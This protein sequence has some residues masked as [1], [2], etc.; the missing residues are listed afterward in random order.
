MT[1]LFC[2]IDNAEYSEGAGTFYIAADSLNDAAKVYKAY[3]SSHDYWGDRI[4]CESKINKTIAKN[5]STIRIAE[6][7]GIFVDDSRKNCKFWDIYNDEY[8]W[9]V[10]F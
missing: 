2:Y 6:C 9:K 3:V 5:L 4:P 8:D 10:S 7:P 1:K